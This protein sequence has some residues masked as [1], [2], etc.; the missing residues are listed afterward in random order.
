MMSIMRVEFFREV[1]Y[2]PRPYLKRWPLLFPFDFEK[3]VK[4]RVTSSYVI[5]FPHEELFAAI[6]DD[7]ENENYS[8]ISRG[9]YPERVNR[10]YIQQKE[11]DSNR[12]IKFVKSITPKNL[13]HIFI[14]LY[15]F[16][17]RIFYTI[18]SLF[19]DLTFDS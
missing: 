1:L 14:N 9:L 5:G 16:G 4:D 13:K 17:K 7:H 11:Y 2:C 18:N 6:D 10:E 19:N 8:L 12:F 15:M 3:K